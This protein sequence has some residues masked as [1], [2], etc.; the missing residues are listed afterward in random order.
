MSR[1]QSEYKP[2]YLLQQVHDIYA[3]HTEEKVRDNKSAGNRAGA[4]AHDMEEAD[5]MSEVKPA[6]S[7]T[8]RKEVKPA[9][10]KRIKSMALVGKFHNVKSRKLAEQHEPRVEKGLIEKI[11][12]VL[13]SRADN[14]QKDG[15]KDCAEYDVFRLDNAMNKSKIL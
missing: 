6:A 10:S 5:V 2:S 3:D 15:N 7:S 1:A 14:V 11:V 12:L 4:S 8:L 9:M 13:A